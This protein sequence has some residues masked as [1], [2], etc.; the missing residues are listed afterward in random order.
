MTAGISTIMLGCLASLMLTMA[1]AK[2]V[3]HAWKLVR[4]A[5]GHRQERGALERIFAASVGVAAG[6]L[7]DL[8][9]RDPGPGAE[10]RSEQ[11]AWTSAT[12]TASSTTSTRRRSN[13]GAPRA[14]R[15]REGGWR[16]RG[17]PDLD[18]SGTEWPDLPHSEI[19]NAAIARARGWVNGYPDRHAS[20]VAARCW[21]SATAVAPEQMALGNG[22]AE[23]LQ[24]GRPGPALAGRRAG[25]ALAVL[26]ALS[27]DGA[28]TRARAV[29]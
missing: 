11:L 8:V 19:V 12:T 16:W 6:G 4:R 13:R 28:R 14:R 10:P 25:D 27:A 2:R 21:P 18:L 1:L 9:L 17:C 29:R 3:D 23:L 5:A 15:Q 7:R 24:L 22:A 20:A 26:P